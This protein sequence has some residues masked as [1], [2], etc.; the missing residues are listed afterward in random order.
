MLGYAFSFSSA[1]I[2][3]GQVYG[4]T[5]NYVMAMDHPLVMARLGGNRGYCS[6]VL[7]GI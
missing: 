2:E 4:F 7:V 6:A 3:R 5:L 1:E